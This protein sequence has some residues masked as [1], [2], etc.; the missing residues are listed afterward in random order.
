METEFYCE[1]CAKPL[2]RKTN[3]RN[4]MKVAH[5]NI[6]EKYICPFFPT[7]NGR[8]S[9]GFF[10]PMGNL[11]V[12]FLRNHKEAVLNESEVQLALVDKQSKKTLNYF[13]KLLIAATYFRF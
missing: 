9:N 4:H 10:Y 8:K 11:R 2:K 12:H 6:V 13:Q 5:S 1:V 7:C 3:I